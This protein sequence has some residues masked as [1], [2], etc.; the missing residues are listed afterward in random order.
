[1]QPFS[2]FQFFLV[3]P[4]LEL[5]FQLQLWQQLQQRQRQQRRQQQQQLRLLISFFLPKN[6]SILTLY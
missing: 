4:F 5:F 1:V 3:L 2:L 6:M